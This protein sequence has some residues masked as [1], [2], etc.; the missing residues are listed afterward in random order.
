MSLSFVDGWVEPVQ[1]PDWPLQGAPRFA[2]SRAYEIFLR[3]LRRYTLEEVTGRSFLIAGHRGAGKTALVTQAVEALRSERIQQSVQSDVNSIS[4]RGRLQR[5]LLVRLAAKSL[6]AGPP[7]I[8]PSR[9][10]PKAPDPKDKPE[11]LGGKDGVGPA[12][13]SPAPAAPTPPPTGDPVAGA[14]VH[15]TIALYRALAQE[16]AQGFAFHAASGAVAGRADRQELAAQLLLDLDDA[17]EPAL[18]RRKWEQLGR[19]RNG[20]LW[21]RSAQATLEAAQIEDQGLRE[22]VALATAAQAFQVV[23]GNVTYKTT[24]SDSATRDDETKS[25]L[26]IKDLVARL[27]AVF[28]GTAAGSVT[29]ATSGSPT[30]AVGLGLLVWLGS[31]LTLSQT[32]T[33]NLHRVRS[34]D[35]TFLRDRSVQTLDREL[36]QVIERIRDAGLAPIFVLDELDKL[37]DV[38]ATIGA[39]I[40]R[41]KHIVSDFGFFCFLTNRDYYDTVDRLVTT[42]AY[43]SEHTYFSDRLLIIARS[44]DLFAYVVQLLS[45]DLAGDE[46]HLPRATFALMAIYRSK[47]NFTDLVRE[48]NRHANSDRSLTLSSQ[49]LRERR[50]LRLQ[51]AVQLASDEALRIEPCAT[52]FAQDEAFA[53]LAVDALTYLPRHW[54]E[55]AAAEIDCS[56][57]KL[58]ADLTARMAVKRAATPAT[59]PAPRRGAKTPAAAA[60][61]TGEKDVKITPP[62]LALVRRLLD[63]QLGYLSDFR[64]LAQALHDRPRPDQWRLDEIV[65]IEVGR[66]LIAPV[67]G[68]PA[69][70]KFLLDTA[71]EPT[72]VAAI[73]P[74]EID[75]QVDQLS[76]FLNAFEALLDFARLPLD[77]LVAAKYLPATVTS[78]ALADARKL[79]AG[80]DHA[81]ELVA[82]AARTCDLL[83]TAL[84]TRRQAL[85]SVLV[86]LEKFRVRAS[87]SRS[88]ADILFALSRY[89]PSPASGSEAVP[90][91]LGDR[92]AD[93]QAGSFIDLELGTADGLL[94][95]RDGLE[96]ERARRRSLMV[97]VIDD[98]ALAT[99]WSRWEGRLLAWIEQG[100]SQVVDLDDEDIATA[101]QGTAPGSLFKSDLAT[102]SPRDWSSAAVAGLPNADGGFS[103]PAWLLFVSL[104]ALGFDAAVMQD[105]LRGYADMFPGGAPIDDAV[106][107]RVIARAPARAPRG[108]LLLARGDGAPILGNDR[109]D[110][111]VIVLP[112]DDFERYSAAVEWLVAAGVIEGRADESE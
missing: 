59:A 27:G 44:S 24:S 52:R 26:D 94:A 73:A 30:L 35:Y 105:L 72:A 81:P 97:P 100:V 84:T 86:A 34:R 104:Y 71:A 5:P 61:A 90:A 101:A 98:R 102:M 38:R 111:P 85:A 106:A 95:L 56:D 68:K 112:Q 48:L 66:S 62:D 7:P 57:A 3:E 46:D 107:R 43:P 58:E 21:P 55:N 6:I 14:L 18:L 60:P 92:I 83:R 96:G 65:P 70:Y 49:A 78:E 32:S 51:A 29:V 11:A 77:V 23:S 33:R 54:E 15:L 9:T 36:P 82:R 4:R 16:V 53:Q 37:D 12:P 75:Q 76:A 1:F 2:T 69:C 74:V 19:L 45:S 17:P 109:G 8:T 25:K 93:A 103:P 108:L 42:E 110:Q 39:L 91:L 99:L 28:A 41:L 31:S 87:A 88:S 20:V 50:D 40:S 63:R 10:A 89:F 64:S 13:A 67:P 22:I 47:L 80:P 79:L